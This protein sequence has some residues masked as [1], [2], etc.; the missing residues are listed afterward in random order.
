[1]FL[2]VK[3]PENNQAVCVDINISKPVNQSL[4]VLGKIL[5]EPSDD[6]EFQLNGKTLTTLDMVKRPSQLELCEQD[7]LVCVRKRSTSGELSAQNL[8]V[9]EDEEV[10]SF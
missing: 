5:N 10:L 4:A 6:L 3:T 9:Q 2:K 8:S 7:D 1:M